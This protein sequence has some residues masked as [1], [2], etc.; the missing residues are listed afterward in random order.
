MI[1][2]AESVVIGT[3]PWY[4][5]EIEISESPISAQ[6]HRPIAKILALLTVT[7]FGIDHGTQPHNE[8]TALGMNAESIEFELNRGSFV[9]GKKI[10]QNQS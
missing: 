5:D 10:R 4:E 6:N 3:R 1:P 9:V 8:T 2:T 7:G